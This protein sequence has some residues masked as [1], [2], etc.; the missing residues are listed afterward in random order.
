MNNMQANALETLVERDFRCLSCGTLGAMR[1]DLLVHRETG[2][3]VI[4][5]CHHGGFELFI[6]DTIL[7]RQP[8]TWEALDSAIETARKVIA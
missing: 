2:L 8:A 6:Q 1:F 3:Q 4:F 5:A 7:N